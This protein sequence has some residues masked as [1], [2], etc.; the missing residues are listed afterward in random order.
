MIYLITIFRT[1]IARVVE[2][3]PLFFTRLHRVHAL[4]MLAHG[5]NP[6]CVWS[7][8]FHCTV[9]K[10]LGTRICDEIKHNSITHDEPPTW[11]FNWTVQAYRA[12]LLAKKITRKQEV[13][14]K[15]K[16]T[17]DTC[18]AVA[19]T[20]SKFCGL[21]S[22]WSQRGTQVK[23]LSTKSSLQVRLLMLKV[24]SSPGPNLVLVSAWVIMHNKIPYTGSWKKVLHLLSLLRV[25]LFTVLD[26]INL[27]NFDELMNYVFVACLWCFNSIN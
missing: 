21:S 12:F 3:C 1:T 18:T 6:Y 15:F 7:I 19:N 23:F 25:K 11:C 8:Q 22:H 24:G 14:I 2:S 20:G 13:K 9:R 27:V 5:V 10:L 4:C 26:I 16:I 17:P